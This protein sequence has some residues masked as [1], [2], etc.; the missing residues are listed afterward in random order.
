[1]TDRPSLSSSPRF[2]GDPPLSEWQVE[3]ADGT[4]TYLAHRG[5]VSAAP[6]LREGPSDWPQP[7]SDDHPIALEL[8]RGGGDTGSDT[9][10]LLVDGVQ[11]RE[12]PT[13]AAAATVC[14]LPPPFRTD[15]PRGAKEVEKWLDVQVRGLALAV[16]LEEEA[17][18]PARVQVIMEQVVYS[19][20]RRDQTPGAERELFEIGRVDLK[21]YTTR[22]AAANAVLLPYPFSAPAQSALGIVSYRE[23]ELWN[24][25]VKAAEEVNKEK[26]E[27]YNARKAKEQERK[28]KYEAKRRDTEEEN[29]DNAEKFLR[30]QAEYEEAT[31]R[32]DA[33]LTEAIRQWDQAGRPGNRPVRGKNPKKPNA[34]KDKV[35]KA[36]KDRVIKQSKPITVNEPK[37]D[38]VRWHV[39]GGR[40]ESAPK[41]LV[42][43]MMRLEQ[44]CAAAR[45]N[46]SNASTRTHVRTMRQQLIYSR[47]TLTLAFLDTLLDG[48]PTGV[49][50]ETPSSTDASDV[51]PEAIEAKRI[52]QRKDT[53]QFIYDRI[54]LLDRLR[55]TTSVSMRIEI[56]EHDGK[57]AVLRL[58]AS[59]YNAASAHAVYAR[60][61]AD[62]AAYRKAAEGFLS[63]LEGLKSDRGYFT[64]GAVRD[65]LA[66]AGNYLYSWVKTVPAND[67]P[68]DL[69]NVKRMMRELDAAITTILPPAWPEVPV[70]EYLQEATEEDFAV[71]EE[72]ETEV[73]D[74]ESVATIPA[75]AQIDGNAANAIRVM[76]QI[77]HVNRTALPAL[78]VPMDTSPPDEFAEAKDGTYSYLRLAVSVATFATVF[79]FGAGVLFQMLQDISAATVAA[80]AATTIAAGFSNAWAALLVQ[81][82]VAA[83]LAASAVGVAAFNFYAGL[84]VATAVNAAQAGGLVFPYAWYAGTQIIQRGKLA[85]KDYNIRTSFYW[86]ASRAVRGVPIM[87]AIQAARTAMKLLAEAE[88]ER[89]RAVDTLGITEAIFDTNDGTRFRFWERV[90][91]VNYAD[92]QTSRHVPS[93]ADWV[94]VADS[95][96]I[97]AFPPAI[98]SEKIYEAETLRRMPLPSAVRDVVGNAAADTAQT[99]IELAAKVA[100]ME[101][102]VLVKTDRIPLRG[103]HLKMTAEKKAEHLALQASKLLVEAF[104]KSAGVTL[105]SGDDAYWGALAGGVA[106]RLAIR[107]LAIFE[108]ADRER[109]QLVSADKASDVPKKAA[110]QWRYVRRA[111]LEDFAQAWVAFAKQTTP[112]PEALPPLT[113]RDK[114]MLAGRRFA[115]VQALT[116]NSRAL[117][118]VASY[119]Y[120]L[121]RQNEDIRALVLADYS[122]A[123]TFIDQRSLR[124][125]DLVAASLNRSAAT[126]ASRRID[127]EPGDTLKVSRGVDNV[128]RSMAAL[129]IL[130]DD[131]DKFPLHYYCP[132]G[133]RLEALPGARP[134]DLVAHGERMVWLELMSQ[135]LRRVGV[136]ARAGEMPVSA[137]AAGYVLVG[138][139][140]DIGQESVTGCARH[141]LVVTSYPNAVGAFLSSAVADG[142]LTS[143]PFGGVETLVDAHTKFNKLGKSQMNSL[144]VQSTLA[145]VAAFDADRMTNAIALAA[146]R[147][148]SGDI[149]CVTVANKSSVLSLAAGLALFA[150]EAGGLQTE[151]HVYIDRAQLSVLQQAAN[152]MASSC[153]R[154]LE[155]G[156][157]AVPLAELCLALV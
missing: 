150:S 6:V 132:L 12:Q 119:S 125:P 152:E 104:G 157:K 34:K 133:S 120:E 44:V 94:S 93:D 134:F 107:H 78:Q 126:W 114:T 155:A 35:I 60:Y 39:I 40:E 54:H 73:D 36:F 128:I 75:A 97:T 147:V 23:V 105:V 111:L 1:M 59:P 153:Q 91:I 50:L 64:S 18:Q 71:E 53:T 131:D 144:R 4:E 113:F 145:R 98:V 42:K 151:L 135:S 69:A 27:K 43:I 25:R 26:E 130:S 56:T 102:L 88:Q 17:L 55:T 143:T 58:K 141:P 82:W 116:T 84:A 80:K 139:Y 31:Q 28:E 51:T 65:Y 10:S 41:A 127:R 101:L 70:S 16:R 122:T 48:T 89:K 5:T 118:V 3:G 121:L 46:N 2:P 129:D 67:Q 156:C 115:R 136:A 100:H 76:P 124:T 92:V 62:I 146:S 66:G 99:P 77:V 21:P 148:R 45:K 32:L 57:R 19:D 154:A 137:A 83:G 109:Q 138:S 123:R 103:E 86:N 140:N 110:A 30:E 112:V 7:R 11:C 87:S 149:M 85:S 81:P 15:M 47:E 79:Y 14:N 13:P 38:G 20:E 9:W 106:A 142:M 49:D 108:Q 63:C 68:L 29:A 24:E 74:I 95:T 72:A 52:V 37:P 96:A 61:A 22:D 33:E 117:F 90:V 8:V